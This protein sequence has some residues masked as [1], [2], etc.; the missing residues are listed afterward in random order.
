MPLQILL[1]TIFINKGC[2]R[3]RRKLGLLDNKGYNK[4]NTDV[5]GKAQSS[6]EGI[7]CEVTE[8]DAVKMEPNTYLPRQT[9]LF[10]ILH[11]AEN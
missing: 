1:L 3:E 7:N 10:L 5:K 2:L 8:L 11:Q 9:N 6:C 4:G